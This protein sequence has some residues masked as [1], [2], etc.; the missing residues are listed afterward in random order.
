MTNIKIVY[1]RYYS[2]LQRK[3][4]HAKQHI[5]KLSIIVAKFL[6]IAAAIR[7]LVQIDQIDTQML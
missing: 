6:N 3:I 1:E 4:F 5:F 2:S 7:G